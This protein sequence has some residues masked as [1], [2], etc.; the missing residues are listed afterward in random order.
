V[1][2]KNIR[3]VLA[4]GTA[5][6]I[7]PIAGMLVLARQ[8]APS[9]FGIFAAWVGVTIILAIFFTGRFDTILA[10]IPDGEPRRFA[11]LA[12]IVT[13]CFTAI[14]S[15]VFI[16][17]ILYFAPS[18]LRQFTSLLVALLV[19]M[20]MV[21]ALTQ[22]WQSWA[23]AEGKYH[24]LNIMRITQTAGV[25]IIQ[26]IVGIY[27]PTATALGFAYFAGVMASLA[28]SLYLMLPGTFPKNNGKQMVLKFWGQH[29][30]SLKFSLPADLINSASA[31]LPVFFVAS[32]YGSEIA[33]LLAMAMRIIGAPIGLLGKSVLDVFKRHA[34]KA[35]LE[36]LE[37]KAEYVRTFQVLAIASLISCVLIALLSEP[38]FAYAFGERWRGSGEFVIWLLPL[39]A[40]RFIASPL[41]YMT[42][43]AGKQHL[44]LGWQLLLLFMT[45][46]TLNIPQTYEIALISYSIG[47]SFLYIIYLKMSY[48]MSLGDHR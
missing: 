37:C 36:R 19:P 48:K 25:T 35:Y 2:W 7:I 44:D 33:G 28:V 45:A 29:I 1:Y 12:I 14:F 34:S 31:Q 27:S 41:S 18:L 10:T 24:Y 40:L 22:V 42:Y 26:I 30:R 46:I 8:Y 6:Q 17:I 38:F 5:A 21:V 23:A 32:N 13:I 20:G 47:Y 43:I 4:G 3:S 9:D 15:T 11:V 16:C 39:Y